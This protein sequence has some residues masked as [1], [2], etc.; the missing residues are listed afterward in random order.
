MAEIG[1]ERLAAGH[2]EEHRA[3]RDEADRAV[4]QQ[5]LDA[6]ERIDRRQHRRIVGDVRQAQHRQHA[7]HTTMTGPK[8]EAT[9]AVPL[10]CTE[11]STTRMNTVSGTT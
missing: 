2:R 6:V 1:V 10:D 11:N 5:E 7:N 3:E 9:R 8:A 4:R